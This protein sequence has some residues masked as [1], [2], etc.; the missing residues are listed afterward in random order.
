MDPL[1]DEAMLGGASVA[2]DGSAEL[3]VLIIDLTA[4][5]VSELGVKY[6]HAAK[7]GC[8]KEILELLDEGADNNAKDFQQNSALILAAEGGR[9]ECVCVCCWK[10]R[11]R[12]KQRTILDARR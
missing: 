3:D 8:A 7:N 2:Q 4:A 10:S 11:P 12:R 9:V 1:A 6:L 5:E